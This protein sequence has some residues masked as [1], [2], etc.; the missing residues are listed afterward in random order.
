MKITVT[1][2]GNKANTQNLKIRYSHKD[3]MIYVNTGI[4]VNP[5]HFLDQSDKWIK[6]VAADHVTKNMMIR[7]KVQAVQEWCDRYYLDN[8]EYPAA[9]LVQAHFAGKG[10][11][12]VVSMPFLFEAFLKDARNRDKES[13]GAEREAH[14]RVTF[15]YL[16]DFLKKNPYTLDSIDENFYYKYT[17]YL[18]TERNNGDNTI[19]SSVSRLKTFLFWCIKNRHTKLDKDVVKSF[20]AKWATRDIIFH[21]DD[22]LRKMFLLE[23]E[24]ERVQY[25]LREI[26]KEIMPHM[27][28]EQQ[29]EVVLLLKRNLSAELDR[30][31]DAYLLQCITAL[32]HSDVDPETWSLEGAFL[33][34]MPKKTI[35]K[36]KQITVHLRPEAMAIIQKYKGRGLPFPDYDNPTYNLGIK[37]LGMLAGFT[38]K[39]FIVKGRKEYKPGERIPKFLLMS[40]HTARA[41]NVV[42]QLRNNV[43]LAD[44][45][46]TTGLGLP[47]LKYYAGADKDSIQRSSEK[48]Y[49]QQGDL[50]IVHNAIKTA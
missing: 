9:K 33:S 23:I 19:S 45:M 47:T 14:Y 43:S 24:P 6:P 38:H 13:I 37:Q 25:Q 10:A 20:N 4:V 5:A 50:R 30:M 2:R 21:N 16:E 12:E 44:L 28:L 34:V 31:R 11:G 35:K 3:E 22:E 29:A 1:L 26:A 41:T 49:K 42:M 48:M 32:R 40:S 46:E 39:V 36:G 18:R 15:K 8:L 27:E 17:S 7:K